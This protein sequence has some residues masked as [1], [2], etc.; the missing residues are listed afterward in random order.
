MVNSQYWDKY[1]DL[2][3]I[4]CAAER[5]AEGIRKAQKLPPGTPVPVWI[6]CNCPR[7]RPRYSL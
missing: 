3:K 4:P 7:C 2:D 1:E 5:C 6:V